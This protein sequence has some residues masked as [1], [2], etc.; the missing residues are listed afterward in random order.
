MNKFKDFPPT[1]YITLKDSTSRQATI[2]H[3]LSSLGIDFTKIIAYD[4]RLNNYK[5][6]NN[7]RGDF[8]SELDSGHIATILSHIKAIEHWYTT[9]NSSVAVFLED[10]M[11]LTIS[12]YWNFT[13]NN[14]YN[15]LQQYKWN[16]VQLSLIRTDNAEVSLDAYDMC[17]RRRS[18]YNWSAGA[19]MLTKDY[20]AKLLNTYIT[21]ADTY[22]LSVWNY[23]PLIENI[24]YVTGRPYEF[25][26]P[27]FIEDTSY[28][29]TFYPQFISS[30]NKANQINSAEFVYNWWRTNGSLVNIDNFME[31]Q[32]AR[33]WTNGGVPPGWEI[34][35]Q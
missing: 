31:V 19:Y 27:L 16:I 34:I 18:F 29:S 2:E 5:T 28:D 25:T 15:K 3:R 8:I 10:D 9:S 33:Y 23:T 4:G 7:I 12:K 17:F 20:A 1:Y 26:I 22:N 32:E 21:G 30:R 24:L 13:W 35:K 11:D 6:N 14:L